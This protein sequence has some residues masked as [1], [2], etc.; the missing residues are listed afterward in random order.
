[1]QL[2]PVERRSVA[3][4]VFDQLSWQILAG[5]VEA[6]AALPAE[7]ALTDSLGVNRQDHLGLV[8]IRHGGVTR[9]RDFR[10]SGSIDLLPRLVLRPDGTLDVGVIRSAM[11]MRTAIGTDAAARCAERAT[12]EVIAGLRRAVD[13]IQ[14][15]HAEGDAGLAAAADSEFWDWVVEGADNIAYRL[16]LNS[17]RNSYRPVA[18]VVEAVISGELEDVAGHQAIAEAIAA[19][20]GGAARAAATRLLAQGMAAVTAAT[21][22]AGPHPVP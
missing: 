18:T 19:G 20:D 5:E 2:D 1:M 7:R 11:E 8:E 17:L 13:L 22:E 10:R 15:A 6:G 21:V 9:V 12:P 3:S 4:A 14:L 16:S